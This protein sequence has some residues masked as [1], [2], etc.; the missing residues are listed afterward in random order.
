MPDSARTSGLSQFL[1]GRV[2]EAKLSV[3]GL[4]DFDLCSDYRKYHI[5][6]KKFC[7]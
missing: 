2:C 7:L 5:V 3:T 4:Q 6:V 1:M